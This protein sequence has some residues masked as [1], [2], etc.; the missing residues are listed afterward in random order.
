[1]KVKEGKPS[2]AIQEFSDLFKSKPLTGKTTPFFPELTLK[3]LE[4]AF[5]RI[6]LNDVLLE[7]MPYDMEEEDWLR[8]KFHSK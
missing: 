6:L 8:H 1:M 3:K 5:N 4:E 2:E 7:D